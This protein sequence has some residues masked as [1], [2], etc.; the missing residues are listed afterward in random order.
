[1]RKRL[2]LNVFIFDIFF[3]KLR[4]KEGCSEGRRFFEDIL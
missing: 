3:L 1:M 2:I 4:V